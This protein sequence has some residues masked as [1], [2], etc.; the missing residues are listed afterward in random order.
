MTNKTVVT[1]VIGADGH[2]VSNWVLRQI[3]TQEGFKVVSLGASVSQQ[4][5]VNAALETKADAILV[6]SIYGQ[7]SID[8]EG[9]RAKCD[10]AGLGKILL[11]VGGNLTIGEEEEESVERKFKAMGFNRVYAAQTQPIDAIKDLK[12]DLGLAG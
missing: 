1:G 6:S 8:C 3:L 11:Y 4:E 2:I 5:F 7:G 9:F 10:E 12:K